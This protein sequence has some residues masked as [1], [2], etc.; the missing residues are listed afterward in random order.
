MKLS[1]TLMLNISWKNICKPRRSSVLCKCVLCYNT[2]WDT[3]TFVY[4]HVFFGHFSILYWA[5]N[6]RKHAKMYKP[7]IVGFGPTRLKFYGNSGDYYL[8]NDGEKSKLWCLFFIF[9]FLTSV[10]LLDRKWAWP[11]HAPLMV[12]GLQ[13][14]PKSWPTG[15]TFW[16]NHYLEII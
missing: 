9:D 1:S 14:W 5:I 2:K 7:N 16:A 6:H 15:W 11:P 3:A 4:F 12:Q 13:A 8:S 10:P